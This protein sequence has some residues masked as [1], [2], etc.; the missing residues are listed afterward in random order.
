VKRTV[1]YGTAVVQEEIVSREG[2]T[3]QGGLVHCK[4]QLIGSIHHV[5]TNR[6]VKGYLRV[7]GPSPCVFLV[8]SS[9]SA[10]E[11]QL[12]QRTAL[13]PKVNLFS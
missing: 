7:G 6:Y 11:Q 13:T 3:E 5:L 8:M 12:V 9:V 10:L 1:M 2:G 4:C